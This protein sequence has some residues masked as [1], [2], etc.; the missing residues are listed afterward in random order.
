MNHFKELPIDRDIIIICSGD[1]RNDITPERYKELKEK[2]FIIGIN[3]VDNV[4]PHARIWSDTNVSDYI[5]DIEKNCLYISRHRAFHTKN[6]K[7]LFTHIDYWF[8][9]KEENFDTTFYDDGQAKVAKWT[10]YW[11]LQLLKKYFPKR[12]I[13]IIGMDCNDNVST[14]FDKGELKTEPWDK[15]NCEK[16]PAAFEE[17]KKKTPDFFDNVYNLNFFSKVLCMEFKNVEEL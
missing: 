3:F 6:T 14:R 1:S 9:D 5:D 13:H 2:Y 11:L 17:K 4:I 10:L 8:N 7:D 12:A 16:M 15:N